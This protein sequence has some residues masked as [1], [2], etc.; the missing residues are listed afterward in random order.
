MLIDVS[1]L[2]CIW[3]IM[4]NFKYLQMLFSRAHFLLLACLCLEFI[5]INFDRK[6]TYYCLSACFVPTNW[7]LKEETMQ[8]ENVANAV[9]FKWMFL[10][11]WVCCTSRDGY[12]WLWCRCDIALGL[13]LYRS[14]P[15]RV[16][17][18]T[19][20]AT[21]KISALLNHL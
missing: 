2:Q 4:T 17:L 5:Y 8:V 1:K 12:L 9:N 13:C 16:L 6:S 14:R 11:R 3:R 18:T 7:W 19:Y 20:W 10:S 15:V 21:N